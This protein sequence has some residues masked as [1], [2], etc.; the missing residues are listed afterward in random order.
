LQ[1]G[2]VETEQTR[3]IGRRSFREN[4]RIP[5]AVEQGID[6]RVDQAGM[7]SA[8]PAQEDRIVPCR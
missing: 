5:P 3:S 8:A 1:Q 4:G 2:G 6:L 7:P